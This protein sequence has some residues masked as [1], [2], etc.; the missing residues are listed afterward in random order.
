M[1]KAQHWDVFCHV[2]DNYGDI[3]ICWRLSQQ[4]ANEHGLQVRLFIDDMVSAQQLITSLGLGQTSQMVNGVDICPWPEVS[5]KPAQVVIA[6]FGCELPE[7]YSQ[8]LGIHQSIWINLEYL[9]AETWVSDFHAKTSPQP[10]LGVSKHFFF[11][12]FLPDTGGLLREHD[13]LATRD[14]FLG[15]AEKQIAFWQRLGL[16]HLSSGNAIKI[17]LFCYPQ[18]NIQS[19]CSAFAKSAH[20][21]HLVMPFNGDISQLPRAFTDFTRSITG[22]GSWLLKKGKLSVHLLPFLSQADY[23]HLLWACD[24]NFVRG[25]DSWIRAIWASKPFIWQPYWQAD[26]IHIKKMQAFLAVY[27]NHASAD[28]QHLLSCV[29]HAW[30]ANQADPSITINPDQALWSSFVNQLPD[31]R[32]YAQQRANSLAQQP[33]LATKLVIFSENLRNSQV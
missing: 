13:L 7:T 3:G 19:L 18:A 4:L 6:S 9:S 28:L 23:D 33:D 30:S 16:A 14:A 24:L 5:V 8:Q 31:L 12:G 17:S 32:A 27:A 29:H 10:A 21:T 15:S 20:S 26:A 25:E 11:P 2:V 22:V 1:S